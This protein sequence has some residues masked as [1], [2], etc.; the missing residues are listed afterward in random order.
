MWNISDNNRAQLIDTEGNKF[1]GTPDVNKLKSVGTYKTT[2]FKGTDY[3]VTSNE[4]IYSL[5]TCKQVFTS[6]D[7]STKTQKERIINQILDE[8]NLSENVLN[9]INK[10]FGTDKVLEYIKKCKQNR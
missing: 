2:I 5:D 1:S 10:E 6:L 9:Q 7:N 3:I 4:N 8:N